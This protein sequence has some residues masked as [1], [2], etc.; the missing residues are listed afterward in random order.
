MLES[1][2]L[3]LISLFRPFTALLPTCNIPS[4]VCWHSSPAQN[5]T[6]KV[7]AK[8]YAETVENV[9]QSTRRILYRESPYTLLSMS[10]R[11]KYNQ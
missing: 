3:L 8:K 1:Q 5:V 11:S 9:Q 10:F 2:I 6:L 4:S 7:A